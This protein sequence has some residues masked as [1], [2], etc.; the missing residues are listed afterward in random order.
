MSIQGL[1][2]ITED[3]RIVLSGHR[4][5]NVKMA[6]FVSWVFAFLQ[7]VVLFMSLHYFRKVGLTS[8]FDINF[9]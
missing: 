4:S 2:F 8:E 7:A 1:T 6:F 3:E 5:D 9:Y